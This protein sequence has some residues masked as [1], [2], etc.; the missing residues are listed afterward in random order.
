MP[1]SLFLF[2]VLSSLLCI[3]S[4]K[5]ETARTELPQ[6]IEILGIELRKVEPGTFAMGMSEL[7]ERVEPYEGVR[8]VDITQAYYLGVHEITQSI[9]EKV[10]GSNPS[11]FKGKELPV[12]NVTWKESMAFCE[13]LNKKIKSSQTLPKGMRFRLPSEAE[14]EFAARAGTKSVYFFGDK[15]SSISDYAWISDNSI[16]GTHPVKKKKTN[17][18]GFFDIYG[19][20]REWCLDGYE[21][22]PR[23]KLIDPL[24]GW[25]N[26]DK[27]NRGGSWDSCE[28]CCKTGRR[29]NFGEDY[30]SNDVGFR[31]ALGMDLGEN[32]THD[33][34]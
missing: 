34:D 20:V 29:S 8:S 10:M 12:E 28:D 17:P 9:W 6:R 13:A 14:W 1:F 27:V 30:K 4:C 23:K 2:L 31:V 21:V 7:D 32:L 3:F 15:S 19:N 5:D 25:K 24:L 33:E 16:D 26:M 11:N 18:W 22:R